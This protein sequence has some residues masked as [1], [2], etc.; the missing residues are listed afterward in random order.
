VSE[1]RG[2]VKHTEQERAM[3]L[4]GAEEQ[5]RNLQAQ[6]EEAGTF[7]KLFV[8]FADSYLGITKDNLKKESFSEE[9]SQ[10][11]AEA[12]A[13]RISF[14]HKL[15]KHCNTF[16]NLVFA[17][18]EALKKQDGEFG[19]TLGALTFLAIFIGF[20]VATT[21]MTHSLWLGLLSFGSKACSAILAA[22]HDKCEECRYLHSLSIMKKRWKS[23]YFP[24]GEVKKL[25]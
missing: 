16:W 6:S 23:Q 15:A 3:Q 21:L 12:I 11:L 9:G 22:N 7:S 18:A 2:M 20:P 10:Y 8:K 5:R 25:L 14:V 17:P 4:I 24:V 19:D 1:E 13:K